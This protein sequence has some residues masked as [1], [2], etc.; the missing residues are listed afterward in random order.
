MNKPVC[1]VCNLRASALSDYVSEADAIATGGRYLR[2]DA[3]GWFD[4]S[5]AHDLCVVCANCGSAVSNP[6]LGAVLSC[7][8]CGQDEFHVVQ[9]SA[10]APRRPSYSTLNPFPAP[11]PSSADRSSRPM[12]DEV[13]D[14]MRVSPWARWAA[15]TID[16]NVSALVGALALGIF[17]AI[18]GFDFEN[19]NE[20]LLEYLIAYPAG[21]ALDALCYHLFGQTL[22]KYL[23]ALRV[24][25]QNG[26]RLSFG[27]YLKR[28]FWV[29]V[30]GL[31]L[32]IPLVCI[33]TQVVQYN[34]V[35]AG[36]SASY[37]EGMDL[38]IV[39]VRHSSVRTFFGIAVVVLV[40]LLTIV[41]YMPSMSE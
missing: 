18:L 10:P 16:F 38:E 22:G 34:R 32:S 17:L 5:A 9:T 21:L 14:N 27:A 28:N 30:K 4:A 2:P 35:N 36:K 41:A 33:I 8:D 20:I 40:Y 23:F 26:M 25:R 24:R 13:G 1:R 6:A 15:R 7:P 29:F 39:R 37:D 19:A 11:S 3:A 12:P 31:G